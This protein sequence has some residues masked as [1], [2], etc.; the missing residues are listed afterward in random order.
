MICVC[1][2]IYSNRSFSSIKVK[3]NLDAGKNAKMLLTYAHICKWLKETYERTDNENDKVNFQKLCSKVEAIQKSI[4]QQQ[5]HY[6]VISRLISLNF[7]KLKY[8]GL[9]IDS[10]TI[11]F[12]S[13]FRYKG[14]VD[15]VS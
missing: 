15:Q 8:T 1:E 12:Y 4:G 11:G 10:K 3:I 14:D 2:F 6:T 13:N 5:L 7:G 9:Q